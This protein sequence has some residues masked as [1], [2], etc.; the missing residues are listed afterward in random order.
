MF[1][2][3]CSHYTVPPFGGSRV[4]IPA[5][6]VPCTQRQTDLIAHILTAH[7][8]VLTHASQNKVVH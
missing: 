7:A 3:L 2:T 8:N 1:L 6:S 5:L 4:F